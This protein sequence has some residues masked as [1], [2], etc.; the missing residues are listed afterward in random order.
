MPAQRPAIGVEQPLFRL[1]EEAR[2]EVPPLREVDLGRDRE[3][4]RDRGAHPGRD[5]VLDQPSVD[6]GDH[7]LGL[8]PDHGTGDRVLIA[9][10]DTIEDAHEPRPHGLATVDAEV[11]EPVVPAGQA[12]LGGER[13]PPVHHRR[14]GLVR[15]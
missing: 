10:A 5:R 9:R 7:R 2:N 14:E 3:Q 13:R 15:E 11:V 4:V 8:V 12:D 1:D 6:L